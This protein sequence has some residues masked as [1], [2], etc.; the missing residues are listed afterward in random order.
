MMHRLLHLL[1]RSST[2]VALAVLAFVG[3][4]LLDAAT[5]HAQT[6]VSPYFLVMVDTSGSMTST[7]TG[8]GPN[9]C[10]QTR[11]RI[12]D[13]KCVIQQVVNGY[14]D[15]TFGLGR[16]A[17]T[18]CTGTCSASCTNGACGC[19]CTRTCDATSASGEV[20]VPF[21]SSNQPDILRWVD[22]TC[23][24][25]TA[26]TTFPYA[27]ATNPELTAAG[28]TP[29]G[30]TILAARAYLTTA[31][32]SDP[33]RGCRSVNVIM[34]TDGDETCDGDAE[35]AAR[36]LHDNFFVGGV[37]VVV[38][39][40]FIGFGVAAGDGD[41]ERYNRAGRGIAGNPA[42]NEGYY[43][44]DENT[45]AAAFSQIISDGIALRG[46][47]RR[48]Q[49]LRHPGRRGLPALLQPPD[50]ADHDA[51]E[52][53]ASPARRLCDMLRRQ[54]QRRGRRGRPQRVR[55][56][57]P[58]RSRRSATGSTTTATARSTKAACAEARTLHG[59]RDVR[60]PRRRLRH[61][62]RR[63]RDARLQHGRR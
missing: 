21:S 60:Q 12:N 34:L 20:L 11:R 45:L 10:G 61:A 18:G 5:A 8:T 56:V 52:P 46:L 38:N 62:H 40:Y 37:R 48:R 2:L 3:G 4:S 29:I 39:S 23:S 36:D 24:Q 7:T 59:R 15:V 47:R 50:A 53:S 26:P 17:N 6:A 28:A 42:G 43:A 32:A 25:C 27:A 57:R 35:T 58:R 19:S 1:S 30:G 22:Y 31:L 41:I 49:R 63:G 33:N 14:G 13:A 54:L 55:H 44:T 51:H 9:S 16:F